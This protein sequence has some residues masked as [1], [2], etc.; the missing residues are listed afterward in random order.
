MRGHLHTIALVLVILTL[1]LDL[2]F[3]GAVPDLPDVG[4]AIKRSANSEAVLASTYIFAGGYLDSAIPALGHFG[5]SVMSDALSPAFPQI[6]EQPNLAM[7]LILSS[8]FNAAH[9][10]IKTLYWAPPILFLAY[11]LLWWL[12][13]KA[14]KLIRTR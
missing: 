10:W 11:L 1:L 12:R 9:G 7:D 4:G 6:V 5:A 3:W 13:P 14:V 8:D 2:T